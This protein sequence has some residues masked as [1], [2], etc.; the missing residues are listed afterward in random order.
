MITHRTVGSPRGVSFITTL[1]T[2]QVSTHLRFPNFSRK[3]QQE[4]EQVF[5]LETYRTYG[6][7]NRQATG[8]SEIVC[9]YHGNR[10]GAERLCHRDLER[11]SMDGHESAVSD[12]L[13]PFIGQE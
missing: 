6:F 12:Q 11:L 4:N 3:I 13:L 9:L 8:Q 5:E 2:A 10:T 7:H 1:G